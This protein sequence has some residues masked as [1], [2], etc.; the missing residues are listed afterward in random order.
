MTRLGNN[1]DELSKYWHTLTEDN[2]GTGETR[3][4]L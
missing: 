3:V 2:Q 4:T 1:L